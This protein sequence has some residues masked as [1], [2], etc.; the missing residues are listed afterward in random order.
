MVGLF[1][2]HA[3]V[4]HGIQGEYGVL[5]GFSQG[6]MSIHR[7]YLSKRL[8]T[9]IS[10]EI[11]LV[12]C[13]AYDGGWGRDVLAGFCLKRRKRREDGGSGEECL[14]FQLSDLRFFRFKIGRPRIKLSPLPVN[15]I[16]QIRF[17]E[18]LGV[19]T[20]FVRPVHPGPCGSNDF[21]H[22]PAFRGPSDGA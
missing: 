1:S 3:R 12:S 16:R 7:R 10:I 5:I 11:G 17:Y 14:Y 19:E 22:I 9:L 6:I 18:A 20:A 4:W 8:R 15:S 2:F 13:K 21:E